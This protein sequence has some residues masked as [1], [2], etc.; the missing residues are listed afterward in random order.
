MPIDIKLHALTWVI[1]PNFQVQITSSKR[2]ARFFEAADVVL[3]FRIKVLHM[4]DLIFEVLEV[5]FWNIDVLNL[6]LDG[7]ESLGSDICFAYSEL[8]SLQIPGVCGGGLVNVQII[9]WLDGIWVV[10]TELDFF[11]GESNNHVVNDAVFLELPQETVA[12]VLVISSIWRDTD[13]P[14]VFR[15]KAGSSMISSKNF[16]VKSSVVQLDGIT[17]I[18]TINSFWSNFLSCSVDLMDTNPGELVILDGIQV[19]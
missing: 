4:G 10:A 8:I 11:V 18:N 16:G 12:N 2:L 13:K 6:W 9:A 1:N 19:R 17:V 5:H 15:R 7:D 14:I 3:A